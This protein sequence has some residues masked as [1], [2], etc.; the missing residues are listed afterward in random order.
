MTLYPDQVPTNTAWVWYKNRVG[1]QTGDLIDGQS[2]VTSS[3]HNTTKNE[4]IATMEELGANPSSGYTTVASRLENIEYY[5]PYTYI[6]VDYTVGV[7]DIHL[8]VSHTEAV[9]ITIPTLPDGRVLSI[10]DASRNASTYNI[11][12]SPI[13]G[14]IEGQGSITMDNDGMSVELYNVSGNWYTNSIS[15]GW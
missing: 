9:T 1:T 10:K 2:K 7:H 14:T 3:W 8:H 12:L 6:E 4:L 5:M 13:T 11:T 15:P